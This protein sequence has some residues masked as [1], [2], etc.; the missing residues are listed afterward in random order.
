MHL[1][2]LFLEMTELKDWER[3]A[4]ALTDR[5]WQLFD[6]LGMEALSIEM[7]PILGGYGMTGS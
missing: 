1:I 5:R 7:L 4:K 3:Y 2:L 6:R